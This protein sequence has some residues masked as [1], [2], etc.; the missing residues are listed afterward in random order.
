[1]A[2]QQAVSVT[3]NFIQGLVTEATA[4]RF[5]ENACTDSS[6]VV[7]DETGRVFKRL[8]W[9][10][11]EGAT[12]ISAAAE[13]GEAFSEFQWDSVGGIGGLSFFVQ[14][15]GNLL[16]FFDVSESADEISDNQR[17]ET[18]DLDTYIAT[19]SS[20]D[21]ADY[22]CDYAY[23]NGKLLVV[24]RAIEPILLTYSL[25]SDSLETTEISVENRDQI[26]VSD[27]LDDN[28][29][30]T[31]T[32]AALITD[33]PAHYYNLLNQSWYIGDALTQWD[34]ARTDVPNNQDYVALYRASETD[35]FD[36]ARVTAQST[37]NRLAPKGHFILSAWCPDHVQAGAD[38]GFT[39]VFAD[40]ELQ[41]STTVATAL[42]NI[43]DF[44]VTEPFF[45]RL[46]DGTTNANSSNASGRASVTDAYAG[47]T[48]EQGTRISK[49]IAYGTN[50]NGFWS[51]TNNDTTLDLYGKQGAAP[52]NSTDGTLLGTLTFTDT[53]NE[54][55]GRTVTSTDTVTHYDHMWVR[56][57]K[58][59]AADALQ[60]N[61]IQIFVIHETEDQYCTT[62]RPTCTEFFAGRAWYA[63]VNF[64]KL[65]SNIYFSQI[66]QKNEQYGQCYQ[67]NDP[68]AEDFFELLADDGGVIIIP[69]IAIVRQL[70]SYQNTLFIMASNGIWS[71]SG[72]ASGF[73]ANDFSVR[74]LSNIGIASS[75]SLVAARGAPVW[76]GTDGIYTIKSTP[77]NNAFE[78]ATI[79]DQV[80]GSFIKDIP[81]INR[82]YIKGEFDSRNN[83]LVWLYST[84]EE[85]TPWEYN[86]VL[87]YN[88][89][90]GAF[91]PLTISESLPVIT[92][93]Q[94]VIPPNSSNPK[95]KYTT[96]YNDTH[97]TFSELYNTS[98]RD[99]A[100]L[101]EIT[102]NSDITQDYDAEFTTGYTLDAQALRFAQ[103]GYVVIYSE[104]IP[105]SSCFVQGVYDF[106]TTGD[107]GKFSTPQ[108]VININLHERGINYSRLKIRGKGRSLQLHFYGEFGKPFT[109]IGWARWMTASASV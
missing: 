96:M 40:T 95:L 75:Q 109:L 42:T 23:G 51:T 44:D 9:D 46:Y 47:K 84:N 87:M 85:D 73:L 62:E 61:E 100:W 15:K 65:S 59:L 48:F 10:I 68:T 31:S 67:K 101:A 11:E 105:L 102:L 45:D 2:R 28:E 37:G 5:P 38:E 4:L 39:F 56:F 83:I 22:V 12:L 36:N 107:S 24:N 16:Y 6:N 71:I 80:I 1:M 55:A 60:V 53:N 91:F 66:I 108:Q 57:S 97:L 34:A 90:S 50:N 89:L 76:W 86:A 98:Y 70:L 41:L 3:N 99:W 81:E 58:L 94:Y 29:R 43:G 72:G 49:I 69:E 74:K 93:I 63:G 78:A 88:G 79:T 8:G 103:P 30:T 104:N 92:G 17:A 14:Q 35:A 106:A 7:F 27:G 26:G 32:V 20:L 52:A 21:P 64:E 19:G 33:N 77:E 18:I 13:A 82:Q 54:A 25:S